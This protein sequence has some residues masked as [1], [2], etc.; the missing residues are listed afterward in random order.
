MAENFNEQELQALFRRHL[1]YRQMPPEFAERLKQQVLAEVANTLQSSTLAAEVKEEARYNPLTPAAERPLPAY[2]RQPAKPKTE[3][4][5]VWNW[6]QQNLRLAPSLSLAG[7]TLAAVFALVVWGPSLVRQGFNAPQTG[8]PPQ[9]MAPGELP[10]VDTANVP[11]ATERA[12]SVGTTEIITATATPTQPSEPTAT[13]EVPAAGNTGE[14]TG[15]NDNGNDNGD[16]N[17]GGTGNGDGTS[18]PTATPGNTGA[19]ATLTV[20]TAT[21]TTTPLANNPS[22]TSVPITATATRQGT[23]EPTDTP[24]PDNSATPT[25]Q[26]AATPTR[27][28]TED[29]TVAATRTTLPLPTKTSAQ[30]GASGETSPFDTPTP[31]NTSPSSPAATSTVLVPTKSSTPVIAP[32]TLASF[33]LTPTLPPTATQTRESTPTRT[34][35]I[36]QPI[37]TATETNTPVP[38]TATPTITDT[39]VPTATPT[40]TDT[41]V[42][43]ATDTAVPTATEVPPTATAT[44]LPPTPTNTLV[45]TATETEVPPTATATAIP[46]NQAPTFER[47]VPTEPIQ[48]DQDFELIIKAIDNDEGD[49]LTIRVLEPEPDSLPWSNWL[50]LETS[51]GQTMLVGKPTRDDVGLYTITL[52]VVD[53]AGA[54][55]DWTFTLTVVDPNIDGDVNGAGVGDS[56]DV[57][58]TSPIT[59]TVP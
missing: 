27:T 25:R 53:G 22:N 39:P 48:V 16:G 47:E 13:T 58:T 45:P 18:E 52:E 33:T 49:T 19:S 26:G 4:Q 9:V 14:G 42:P 31:T 3:A 23:A 28:P 8:A 34:P 12:P 51:N 40:A 44:E 29:N 24:E 36:L 20:A 57:I 7:A 43:T 5:G 38:P 54:R 50:R 56:A 10:G 1:P 41:A 37:P 32:P 30:G 55:A 6:L 17:N 59:T 35:P 15:G 11:T 21:N 46:T 2:T